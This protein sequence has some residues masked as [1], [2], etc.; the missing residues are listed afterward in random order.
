MS[1]SAG[2][3]IVIKGMGMYVPEQ[4][5]GND[6][7]PA[8]LETSDAWI[9]P[10]TGIEQRYLATENQA[11]SDL[12]V[13]AARQAIE[14][15]GI[16]KEEIDL[17]I[18]GTMSPDHPFPSTACMLQGKLGLNQVGAFDVH[19][20]CSGFIYVLEVG[21]RLMQ[22]GRYRNALIVGA[23]KMSSVVD[24]QDRST[25]VLF[26]DG[27]GAAILSLQETPGYG[28]LD[29]LMCADGSRGDLLC[30]PAGGS[31]KPATIQTLD[32]REGF[33]KMNGKEIFKVA[34]RLM[35]EACEKIL[36][37]NGMTFDDVDCVIPHQANVRII[38]SLAK[39]AGIPREKCFVNIDRYAN[40]SAASIPIAMTEALRQG[41]IRKDSIILLVA[42]GGGLTWATSLIKWH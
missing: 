23:E 16:G 18:V 34:V 6:Q 40:T 8:S 9:R 31:A 26:G 10:R 28:I 30:C 38:D 29:N 13:E 3:S 36:A 32:A 42:F 17:I 25:C 24:W 21:M 41:R 1:P 12:A 5:L 14:S 20:A 15:A 33:L 19:A 27:A 39:H 35:A 11:T 7:L 37:R 22:S 4:C 2:E